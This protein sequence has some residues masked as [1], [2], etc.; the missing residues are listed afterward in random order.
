[1]ADTGRLEGSSLKTKTKLNIVISV[2][3]LMT[4]I[5]IVTKPTTSSHKI[6]AAFDPEF[7]TRPDGYDPLSKHYGFEF[8]DR[9]FLMDPGLMY[10]AVAEGAV[11]VIS[12]Y[13][14]DGR[15][16][17]YNLKVLEDDK[18][19]FPPYQAAFVV[20]GDALENIAGLDKLLD[21]LGG[22]IDDQTMQRL[23]FQ[24]D[25]EGIKPYNVARRFLKEHDLIRADRS[26]EPNSSKSLIIGGKPFTEQE[27]IGEM[28]AI[29]LEENLGLKVIRKFNMG[30]TMICFNALRS[31]DIDLYP[32]YTGT[33]LV[34]ILKKGTLAEP[35]KVFQTVKEDFL[36]EYNLIWSK[37]FGFNNAYAL[38]MKRERARQLE[39]STISDLAGYVSRKK[40]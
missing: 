31:G 30:G 34:S 24:V 9:P 20:R 5:L 39:I 32:E 16:A 19:F 37:P 21:T 14:T 29:L 27:I 13:A 33:A 23:N 4:V 2:V 3:T 35:K 38:V 12:G 11:D 10:M 18:N 36:R 7:F 15:I 17:A 28:A 22:A 8:E 26:S 1:V 6:T 25:E 40:D